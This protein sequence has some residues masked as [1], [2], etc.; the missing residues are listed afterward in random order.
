MRKTSTIRLTTLLTAS[1]L[2]TVS[3]CGSD[4]GPTTNPPVVVDSETPSGVGFQWNP[5][6]KFMD[7]DFLNDVVVDRKTLIFPATKWKSITDTLVVNKT[8]LVGTGTEGAM[9]RNPGFIF[10][11]QK[12]ETQGDKTVLT[13]GQVPAYGLFNGTLSNATRP[14]NAK[15]QK[16]WEDRITLVNIG[17]ESDEKTYDFGKEQLNI[18]ETR[19]TKAGTVTNKAK[20]HYGYYANAHFN[21]WIDYKTPKWNDWNGDLKGV[22]LS[23]DANAGAWAWLEMSSGIEFSRDKEWDLAIPGVPAEIPLNCAGIPCSVRPKLTFKCGAGYSAGVNFSSTKAEIRGTIQMGVAYKRRSDGT[24]V[25]GVSPYS[26]KNFSATP[27]TVNGGNIVPQ[28]YNIDDAPAGPAIAF[29]ASANAFCSLTPKL[30]FVLGIDRWG[31][32]AAATASAG[33]EFK[34]EADI[35]VC[36]K[37]TP[38]LNPASAGSFSDLGRQSNVKF[39]IIPEIRAGVDISVDIGG[40]GGTLYNQEWGPFT[41]IGTFTPVNINATGGTGCP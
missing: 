12:I 21:Y 8:I 6:A 7:E 26:N 16:V 39:S 3:G 38:N 20:L 22:D 17:S 11:V 24:E 30:E 18:T 19:E 41:P 23:L 32:S 34:A 2:A 25:D 35:A 28:N 40:F 29:N 9:D 4:G 14:P 5:N 15:L 13:G 33:I 36:G 1:I 10:L 37:F 27:P 31:L